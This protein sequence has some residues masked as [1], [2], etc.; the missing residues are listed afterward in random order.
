[1]GRKRKFNLIE[2]NQQNSSNAAPSTEEETVE[3]TE[4]IEK[5]KVKEK[6][7]FQVFG[8]D[9]VLSQIDFINYQKISNK[10]LF[11]QFHL[12]GRFDEKG[13]Y[14]IN[15]DIKQDLVR[16][17]KEIQVEDEKG[18]AA[19][20]R[21]ADLIFNF[22]VELSYSQ[23][24]AE[25]KLYIVEKFDEHTIKTLVDSFKAPNDADFR[26]KVRERFN[27]VD[28]AVK[29]G[30]EEVPNLSI[31]I[32]WQSEEY[33][34]W[35]D[36]YEMGSQFFVL[37]ALSI[38]EG[39]GKLGEGVINEYNR[40]LSELED[41]GSKRKFSRA[42]E[43]LDD[44]FNKFGGIEKVDEGKGK[45]KSL[46]KEYNKPFLASESINVNITEAE[47]PKTEKKTAEKPKGSTP[48]TKKTSTSTKS[49]GSAG[50]NGRAKATKKA[51]TK[52][53]N[54]KDDS[55]K[56]T[57][58]VSVSQEKSKEGEVK[59]T[60]QPAD[61]KAG[62]GTTAIRTDSA[63]TENGRHE[64][65]ETKGDKEQGATDKTQVDPALMDNIVEGLAN[66]TEYVPLEG[67]AE[68]IAHEAEAEQPQAQR[69]LGGENITQEN[70]SANN[71][72]VSE[73]V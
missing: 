50:N 32:Y 4:A 52:K 56:K 36:L 21:F 17:I 1:M 68:L 67:G 51:G 62:N 58:Y 45:L 60:N 72:E 61:N 5:E 9:I 13:N 66:D 29:T 37:R 40:R 15:N 38:L 47:R 73:M 69:D 53:P 14:F 44:V 10:M 12:L 25:A 30:D 31:W 34:Y 33:M 11:L 65:S 42:K 26:I 27:L 6:T 41:N 49:G 59:T 48:S 24:G 18:Y 70:N 46:A 16:V 55:K 8:E 39:Y 7:E 20:V 54:T 23:E 35:R 19:E 2:Q 64:P 43:L 28:V 63:K 71:E 57:I 3:K 22:D